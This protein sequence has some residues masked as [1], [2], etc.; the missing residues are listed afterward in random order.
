MPFPVVYMGRHPKGKDMLSRAF[1]AAGSLCRG[2]GSALDDFGVL[3][4]GPQAVHHTLPPNT[5][6]MPFLNSPSTQSPGQ[7]FTVPLGAAARGT[8][9][10]IDIVAPVKGKDVFIA[11]NATVLGNVAIG[12]GSSIWYGAL[13]RGDVNA[14]TVGS[15]TNIQDNVVIHVA[16]HAISGQPRSTQIG[17]RVTVGHGATLHACTVGDGCMV[18]MGATL[19]DGVTM[20]AGSM[21]AAGAVVTPGT[22]VKA[23]QIFAGSPAKLM[24]QL[25][26]EEASFVGASADNYAKLATEHRMENYKSFEE[27]SLDKI[28][29]HEREWRSGTD[30]DVHQ[31]IYRDPQTQVILSMR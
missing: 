24:R 11:P 16:R 31:G 19:L 10:K 3:I 14:I 6:F 28:I 15:N 29:A 30:I 25:T 26:S 5:A 8:Q 4:M 23:G 20:E 21:V 17:S 22:V 13:L 18:G 1:F 7:K 2:I 12:A 27:V 9:Q